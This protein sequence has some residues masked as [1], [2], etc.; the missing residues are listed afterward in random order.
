MNARTFLLRARKIDEEIDSLIDTRN[1][2]RDRVTNIVQSFSA[3]SVQS[4][5]DP[6]KFDRLVELENAIDAKIAELDAIKAEVMDVI[7]RVSD[8]RYR[9]VL[10]LRYIDGLRM[11]EIAVKMNY[12]WRHTCRLHGRALLKVEEIL[13]G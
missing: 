10:K 6:H 11:E 5:P 8:G 12:T 3:V 9:M 2:E 4:T 1:E 7:Y 13:N